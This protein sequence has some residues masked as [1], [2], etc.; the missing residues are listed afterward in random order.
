MSL[1]RIEFLF[2]LS[3]ALPLCFLVLNLKKKNTPRIRRQLVKLL[4]FYFFVITTHN[5]LMVL[6][7]IGEGSTLDLMF[8]TLN[9][10]CM[11]VPFG[12]F[13][14]LF[15]NKIEMN[16]IFVYFIKIAFIAA[17]ATTL[18]SLI[19]QIRFISYMNLSAFALTIFCVFI[20]VLAG[21]Q[22]GYM[23]L[24]KTESKIFNLFSRKELC[25]GMYEY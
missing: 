10:A 9:Y 23:V 20:G 3:L 7:N 1:F 8:T 2:I 25:E 14:P 5:F 19:P 18:I 6:F 13:F 21:I 12:I 24:L 15:K 17:V 11:F 22:I 4:A 16:N